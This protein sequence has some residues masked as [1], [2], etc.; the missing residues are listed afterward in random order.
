M[1]QPCVALRIFFVDSNKICNF[2]DENISSLR[3]QADLRKAATL[4]NLSHEV[5]LGF[6]NFFSVIKNPKNKKYYA[7]YL[8]D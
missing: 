8:H 4:W 7:Y 5:T 3:Q 1:R 2:A 6:L